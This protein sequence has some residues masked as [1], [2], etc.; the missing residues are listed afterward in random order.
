MKEFTHIDEHGRARMVDVSEKEPTVREA[1]ARGRV[2]MSPKTLKLIKTG[3]IRKGDVLAVAQVAGIMAAKRTSELIPMCHPLQITAVDIDFSMNDED[4]T[5]EVEAV[6]KTR[7]RT[8]VE[9]EALVAVSAAALTIYDMCKAVDR[10]I[11]LTDI[12]LVKKT[13]GKSGT[14]IREGEV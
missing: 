3:G 6:V 13:G 1:I 10:A 2:K 7:D 4:S 14:F 9:M 11:T 5:V 12:R 8:G